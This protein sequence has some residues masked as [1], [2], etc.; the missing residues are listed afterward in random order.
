MSDDL[1][2]SYLLNEAD[3]D[4]CAMVEEWIIETTEN[5]RYFEHFKLIW[6]TSQNLASQI[7]VVLLSKL[8]K[9]PIIS[10]KFSLSI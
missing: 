9:S 8:F 7:G 2:V 4:A 6:E 5:R 1:L 3:A 10:L